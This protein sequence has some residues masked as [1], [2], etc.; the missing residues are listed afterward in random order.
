MVI[1]SLLLEIYFYMQPC[2]GVNSWISILHPPVVLQCSLSEATVPEYVL[3]NHI[4][5]SIDLNRAQTISYESSLLG[6]PRQ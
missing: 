2:H 6:E 3:W 4:L 1:V 5:S